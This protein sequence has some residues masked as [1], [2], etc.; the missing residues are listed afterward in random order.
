MIGNILGALHDPGI[1]AVGD[2]ESIA[3]T[4]VGSGGVADVTFSTIPGTYQHLQVRILAKDSTTGS[5]DLRWQYNSD[6]GANY[7]Y[8]WLT[9]SGTAASAGGAANQSYA[10]I[11]NWAVGTGAA[12]TFSVAIIDILDYA[13]T[14]KHKVSRALG[15]RD[16]N[17]GGTIELASASWRNTN[18][19]T[20]IKIY[21]PTGNIPQHSHIA[22]YGIKG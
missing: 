1:V 21:L 9:G 7:S 15:G 5:G 8:H 14:N 16:T 12:N 3:T 17:G 6:T 4:L 19:I 13:N 20:S 18:A 10:N 2:F 11:N 22:L